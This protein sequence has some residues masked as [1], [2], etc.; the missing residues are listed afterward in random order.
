MQLLGK[1][2]E[3]SPGFTGLNLISGFSK[4]LPIS[5]KSRIPNI[6]WA[7]VVSTN[8]DYTFKALLQNKDFYFVH[9]YYFDCEFTEN[10]TCKSSFGNHFFPSVIRKNNLLGVQFHPEKS[11]RIG[12][13]FLSEVLNW[14]DE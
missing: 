9:S 11:S 14:A 13:E 12:H 4:L 3:E 8:R 2:S 5:E 6:G 10:I 1:G 7:E